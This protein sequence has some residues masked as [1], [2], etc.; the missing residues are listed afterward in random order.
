M[1]E[2]YPVKF[3]NYI[4]LEKIGQGGMA[5]I[6]LAQIEGPGKFV[7]KIAIKRI[8]AY[9]SN[10]EEFITQFLDEARI[11]GALN[12]PNI[13]QIYEVGDVDGNFY[14]AMEYV[15]GKHLGQIIHRTVEI[16]QLVPVE[17]ALIIINEIAKAL[18]YAHSATDEKGNPLNIIH[19]DVSPQNI[20]IGFNGTVKLTDFGIAKARNKL[21]QTRADVIKGKFSYLAPELLTGS[22]A[23]PASDLFSLGVVFWELLTGRRLFQGQNDA[24][25]LQLIQQCYVPPIR[26]FRSD[27]SQSIEN[28]IRGLLAPSPQYRYQKADFLVKELSKLLLEYGVTDL[29]FTVSNYVKRLFSQEIEPEDSDKNTTVSLQSVPAPASDDN[30]Y[31]LEEDFSTDSGEFDQQPTFV[32][33]NSPIPSSDILRGRSQ[34]DDDDDKDKTALLPTVGRQSASYSSLE[35]GNTGST[36]PA[37][38]ADK[39]GSDPRRTPSGEM[40]SFGAQTLVPN[41]GSPSGSPSGETGHFGAQTLV[42][43]SGSPGGS[44]SGKTGHFGGIPGTGDNP[45][46]SNSSEVAPSSYGGKTLAVDSPASGS[47]PLLPPRE[48]PLPSEKKLPELAATVELSSSQGRQDDLALAPTEPVTRAKRELAQQ[49][50]DSIKDGDRTASSKNNHPSGLG[51]FPLVLIFL[52]VVG[53]SIVGYVTY[54]AFWSDEMSREVVEDGEDGSASS[55]EVVKTSTLIVFVSPPH[56]EV[57]LNGVALPGAAVRKKG[58]LIPG[59]KYKLIVRAKG[60]RPYEQIIEL[61]E[62]QRK[63]LRIQLRK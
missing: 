46:L 32:M 30:F 34:S 1:N 42:P 3:G 49:Y 48:S 38:S 6:F 19:R 43:S 59:L 23:S 8:L 11:A 39:L 62:G 10:E 17:V 60:Y 44:P 20:L 33:E 40:A 27:V 54:R 25:T 45:T 63:E 52:G 29:L 14:I 2:Q 24:H 21:H 37:Y 4:L 7:K 5:E 12:H 57:K 22:S 31:Y 41:S 13:V 50:F 9:L 28:L 61:G 51:L 55:A 53:I 26:Q 56:A 15:E 35:L 18:A 36:D 58:G 16:G 47:S